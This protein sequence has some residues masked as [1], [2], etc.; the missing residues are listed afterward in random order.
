MI[1][2]YILKPLVILLNHTPR[3]VLHGMAKFM[4]FCLWH[5][6]K[7]RR[8][9][10][11]TNA[12]ILGAK[13]PYK[14]AR[15]SFDYTFMAYLDIFYAHRI[16]DD[17]IKNHVTIEG[18]QVYEK[19][20]N[21][22]NKFVFVGG[23]F[24]TW[25]LLATIV[26]Q[27]LDTQVITIGRSTKNA[28][29]DKILDELRTFDRVKYVTHRGAMEKLSSYINDGCIPGVYI[30]HTATAKDCINANFCGY[31]V[32]VIA[33]IPALCAR[34]NYPIVFFFGLYD[35]F[36]TKV[37]LKGPVYPDKNLKPKE[38][39]VKIAEDINK[40]YEEVFRQYPEQWYLIHRRFKRVELEDGTMSNHVYKESR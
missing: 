36:N 6:S 26:P 27:A 35:G 19:V 2:Y 34:K 39:I 16:G 15:K 24:G 28:A 8:H 23:H 20:K 18:R 10:A 31:K 14:T 38:R 12:K 32:P 25:S 40:V 11:A 9:V 13:D 29:L 7:D 21:E 1:L 17:Y 22:D 33:G 5:L 3:K 30:D 4:A 37:I